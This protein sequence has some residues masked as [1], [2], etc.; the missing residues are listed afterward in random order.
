MT[1]A[2]AL[3]PGYRL[4][5]RETT[6]STNED[7]KGL[8][9]AG[10][11]DGTL[12]WADSQSAGRGRQGRSWASPPG[13]LYA[14]LVLRPDKPVAEA[15]QLSFVAAVA[16]G[17]ALAGLL[18]PTVSITCKWPNDLLLDGRKV[19]G[20]LIEAEGQGSGP[21]DWLVLGFGVNCASHPAETAYPATSLE[22]EAGRPVV[23]GTVLEAF[24]RH[25]RSW[26][27]RWQAEGFAAIRAAWL[28]RAH[29]LGT[30]IEA[31][32]PG[33]TL[34]GTFVD[35][36]RDGVLLL[37][38]ADGTRTRISAGDVYFRPPSPKLVDTGA[39]RPLR[40]NTR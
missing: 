39:G 20:I 8:A 29:G 7:A 19:A 11:A 21:A 12:V 5:R 13:N 24:T 30:A 18:P 34:A 16:L 23:P 33:R 27:Q 31:R 35:L 9:R 3:P 17:D 22:A 32:L 6:D 1:A 15:S 28:D 36:D 37:E 26:R 4:I 10:A 25:F 40:E 2:P 38:A 14:S